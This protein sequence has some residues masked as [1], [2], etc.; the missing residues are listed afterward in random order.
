MSNVCPSLVLDVIGWEKKT[1]AETLEM[2]ICCRNEGFFVRNRWEQHSQ[3]AHAKYR[4]K[5]LKFLNTAAPELECDWNLFSLNPLFFSPHFC[6]NGFLIELCS[7]LHLG[8]RAC[9]LILNSVDSLL[10]IS[11][12]ITKAKMCMQKDQHLH[13][14]LKLNF[15]ILND[16]R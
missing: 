9:N 5:N 11:T 6:L 12:F 1:A 2:H 4:L 10:K 16:K 8:V 7:R 14:F 15:Y 3:C 13:R